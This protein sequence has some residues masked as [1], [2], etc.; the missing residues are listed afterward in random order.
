MKYTSSTDTSC[1]SLSD[2]VV[3]QLL[4]ISIWDWKTVQGNECQK[5]AAES[6]E[7][8]YISFVLRVVALVFLSPVISIISDCCDQ[9]P[10]QPGNYATLT[11]GCNYYNIGSS[12]DAAVTKGQGSKAGTTDLIDVQCILLWWSYLQSGE[13]FV[14]EPHA[15]AHALANRCG[16]VTCICPHMP[17]SKRSW[18]T[19]NK[20]IRGRVAKNFSEIS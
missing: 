7:K 11:A 3:F 2:F 1:V 9:E 15:L 6:A 19:S 13:C 12:C 18:S 20:K 10:H 16:R 14:C 17:C 4:T 8:S 5:N